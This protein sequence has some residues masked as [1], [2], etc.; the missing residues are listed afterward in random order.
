MMVMITW[1][2][3]CKEVVISVLQQT[4]QRIRKIRKL[5]RMGR[6]RLTNRSMITAATL[7]EN[8]S[9][10]NWKRRSMLRIGNHVLCSYGQKPANA[11]GN[12]DA[13]REKAGTEDIG[14]EKS[15]CKHQKRAP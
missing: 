6:V 1:C 5:A 8:I 7:E 11:R 9:G 14:E 12:T 4:T 3:S 10:W 13:A 2:I 15:N